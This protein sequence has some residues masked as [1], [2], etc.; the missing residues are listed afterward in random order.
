L[1]THI[2]KDLPSVLL[3]VQKLTHENLLAHRKLLEANNVTER[4]RQ[5]LLDASLVLKLIQGQAKSEDGDYDI[6]TVT[7]QDEEVPTTSPSQPTRSNAP[8]SPPLAPPPPPP[9][10]PPPIHKFF[11]KPT[12]EITG[13][14]N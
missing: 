9:P 7:Y 13:S 12:K 5:A 1:R 14:A 10:C 3:D 8:P 11:G 4:T 2:P 6:P